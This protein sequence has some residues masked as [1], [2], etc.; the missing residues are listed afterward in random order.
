MTI[1]DK[2]STLSARRIQ[3]TKHVGNKTFLII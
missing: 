3:K 1:L 2:I